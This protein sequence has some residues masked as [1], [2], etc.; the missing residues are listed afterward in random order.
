MES[1]AILCIYRPV[2][3]TGSSN[4]LQVDASTLTASMETDADG[5]SDGPNLTLNFAGS[6]WAILIHLAIS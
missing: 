4:H 5:F 3:P 2:T 1:M 6:M